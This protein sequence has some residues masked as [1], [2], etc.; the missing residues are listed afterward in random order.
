M[1]DEA[2]EDAPAVDET[3]NAAD[4][5]SMRQQKRKAKLKEDHRAAFWKRSLADPAGR[6][7]IWELL[8]A[9]GAFATRFG[10]TPAGFP[11]TEQTWFHLGERAIGERLY[12]TLLK[13]DQ[14]AVYVM[15]QEHDP[16]FHVSKPA[17]GGSAQNQ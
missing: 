17:R 2:E 12:R 9:C 1:I 6:L 16:D 4:P 13:I 10:T 5:A 11:S 8:Q 15:H 14:P 3:P 7:V